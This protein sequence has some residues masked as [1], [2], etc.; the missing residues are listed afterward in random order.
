LGSIDAALHGASA[1]QSDAF[2][3]G[4]FARLVSIRPFLVNEPRRTIAERQPDLRNHTHC[5]RNQ[6]HTKQP[7]LLFSQSECSHRTTKLYGAGVPEFHTSDPAFAIAGGFGKF[8]PSSNR[9]WS[10]LSEFGVAFMAAPTANVKVSGWTCLNQ[11]QTQCS[12]VGNPA[13][14][15]AI[16]FN[17]T[18]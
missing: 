14:P 10:F 6:F 8:V 16:E 1:Q 15:V 7:D 18:L 11:A 2:V 17:S 9:H 12:Y 4:D 3:G 13:N 5:S